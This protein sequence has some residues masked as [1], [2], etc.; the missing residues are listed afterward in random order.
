[1]LPYLPDSIVFDF[2]GDFEENRLSEGVRNYG[3]RI[4]ATPHSQLRLLKWPRIAAY[5]YRIF[6]SA[7]YRIVHIAADTSYK[8]LFFAIPARLAGIQRII[9]ESH[10]SSIGGQAKAL[11][12]TLHRLL[13]PLVHYVCDI[14]IACS[15][16]AARWLWPENVVNS[17]SFRIITNGVDL[18]RFTFREKDRDEFREELGIRDDALLLGHVSNFTF[19]KNPLFILKVFEEAYNQN[20]RAVLL[21][22]G[23]SDEKHQILKNAN[24]EGNWEHNIRDIGHLD[25]VTKAYSAMDAYLQPSLYEGQPIAALEAAASGLDVWLSDRIS[26]SSHISSNVHSL[27]LDLP[28][29]VWANKLV[30]SAISGTTRNRKNASQELIG[31]SADIRSTLR[32]YL[33]LYKS[34]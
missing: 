29:A 4:F 14:P 23:E 13:R 34:E 8:A 15:E 28:P 7:N 11:K 3:G 19:A 10:N 17:E 12:R 25:D 22:I 20:N 24:N 33:M 9:I 6:R 2:L 32:N 27:S 31:S 30:D 26:E 5:S 16:E 21:L 1:M 18:D